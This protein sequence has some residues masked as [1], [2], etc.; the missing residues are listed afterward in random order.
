[1]RGNRSNRLLMALAFLA[2][3]LSVACGVTYSSPPPEPAYGDMGGSRYDRMRI[4]AGRL[5]DRLQAT[6]EELRATR[7]SEADTPLLTD[8]LDRARRFRDR[9]EDTANPPRYVREEVNELD[10]MARDYDARTRYLRASPQA[11]ESWRGAL[12][13]LDRMRRLAS[14]S[15]V[16]LPPERVPYPAPSD[17]SIFSGSALEDLRRTAHEVV[18]RASLARDTVERAAPGYGDTDRRLLADLS[19]FVSGARELDSRVTTTTVDRRDV[20]PFVD[21]LSDDARR[22]DS[23]LRGSTAF[24]RA[25]SDWEEVL[26]LLDRL[27]EMTR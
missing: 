20:A 11:V 14:G 21:R 6:R 3:L 8:L 7:V 15:D 25:G 16:E 5:V 18:V 27:S 24:S 19:Y 2:P 22:I 26:R 17:T 12:D 1:M 10:R 13:T 23:A 9:M 4:L